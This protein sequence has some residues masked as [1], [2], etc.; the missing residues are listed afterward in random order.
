MNLYFYTTAIGRIGIAENSGS[1]TK[2][3]FSTDP[4]PENT[5]SAETAIHLEAAAQLNAYLAGNL[6]EFTLPLAPDG[7][8]FMRT[9]WNCLLD[10]PYGE[11]ISYKEIA[12]NSGHPNASRAAGS[13]CRRNPIPI[14][15]PCHRVISSSGDM[16]G[17]RGGIELKRHLLDLEKNGACPYPIFTIK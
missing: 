5:E 14:F 7:T 9:I 15:I 2:L 1:I 17:Y 8:E 10:I 11:T 16:G 12:L 3:F 6:K 13:A 4:V